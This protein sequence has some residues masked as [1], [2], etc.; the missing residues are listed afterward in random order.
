MA[1]RLK[2]PER[3]LRKYMRSS[4]NC[5][6][7]NKRADIKDSIRWFIRVILLVYGMQTSVIII[8]IPN[9]LRAN[10]L[11]DDSAT[12]HHLTLIEHCRLTCRH[13]PNWRIKPNRSLLPFHWADQRLGLFR[14]ITNL[15]LRAERFTRRFAQY[16]V[17]IACDQFCEA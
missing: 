17:D 10:R 16:P 6:T 1:Y 11:G 4:A 13:I 14:R 8:N 2:C 12:K 3:L 5:G 9:W 7:I 15:H